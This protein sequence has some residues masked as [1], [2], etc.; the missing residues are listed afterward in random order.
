[1]S[2]RVGEKNMNKDVEQGYAYAKGVAQM[3]TGPR[4]NAWTLSIWGADA[5]FEVL[6]SDEFQHGSDFIKGMEIGLDE[7]GRF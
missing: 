6:S 4:A 7:R 3:V 2:E 5:V 1:M